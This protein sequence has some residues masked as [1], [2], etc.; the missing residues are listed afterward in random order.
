[1]LA[2]IEE[3]PAMVVPVALY[4]EAVYHPQM[5]VS[6]FVQVRML[7]LSTRDRQKNFNLQVKSFPYTYPCANAGNKH[8]NC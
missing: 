6:N 4:V 2:G 3:L 1:M 5:P 7:A 8:F